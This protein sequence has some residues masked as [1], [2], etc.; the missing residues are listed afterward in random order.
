MNEIRRLGGA[1][2]LL[3]GLA[4]LCAAPGCAPASDPSAPGAKLHWRKSTPLPEPRAGHAAGLMDGK[5][6]I[7]GGTWWE[8]EKGNWTQKI[9]SA[10]THAFDP[11]SET[12]E[13]LP[14]APF[15]FGYSAHAVVENRLYVLGGFDGRQEIRKILR[16]SRQGEG[17]RWE[18]FGELPRTRLFGW[19][20]SSGSSLYLLGGV[21]RFE[22]TDEAG[23]CCTSKTATN[24]LSVLDTAAPDKGWRELSPYP[25]G[26]RWLF[27]AEGDGNTFWLFGGIDI[28]EAGAPP[29]RFNQ[30]LR[31]DLKQDLW[32]D[33]PPLPDETLEARPLVPL[34]IPGRIL[35]MS[36][37]KTV[38]QLD[39]QT[40]EYSQRTPLPEEAFVDK[41]ALV[42][43]RIIGAGGE[44]RIESPRRRSEWT[45]I[46]E[47]R[48]E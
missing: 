43:G 48:P 27:A 24:S 17:Y 1:I 16:L 25:G 28:P 32:E 31:Y 9:F 39:L 13:R 37:A 2:P 22:P 41:F 46:G 5:F 3:L 8:G 11:Q 20:G 30:A 36:F 23:T 15:P 7:A 44:N 4:V 6:V 21:E 12:W 40:L 26:K 45:F 18:V 47:F 34:H 33:L 42:D 38:W 35:F 10:S 14:D 29:I 19:A